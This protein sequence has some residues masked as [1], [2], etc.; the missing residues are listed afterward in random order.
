MSDR[1][2]DTRATPC[3]YTGGVWHDAEGKP[4]RYDKDEKTQTIVPCAPFNSLIPDSEYF[5]II[6][7]S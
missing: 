1:D 2:D 6:L 3:W 4:V 7:D 5:K